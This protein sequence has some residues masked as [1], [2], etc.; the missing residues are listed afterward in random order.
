MS[1]SLKKSRQ[2]DLGESFR[3]FVGNEACW[4]RDDVGVVMLTG[5]CSQV[6]VPA[7]CGTDSLVLVGCDGHPVAASADYDAK[8]VLS[9]FDCDAQRMYI[10]RIVHRSS[11]IR[12]EILHF[13]AEAS[14]LLD[15][16][17]FVIKSCM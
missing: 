5:Q 11:R 7:K 14:Q 3:M 13:V 10:V 6:L 12:A 16:L 9:A 8:L 1:P 15:Q 17:T 2:E 4:K